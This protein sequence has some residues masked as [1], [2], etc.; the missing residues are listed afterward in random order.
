MVEEENESV[1]NSD[2]QPVHPATLRRS[3]F[4]PAPSEEFE[5]FS[6]NA[7][8]VDTDPAVPEPPLPES[9]MPEP[10]QRRSLDDAQLLNSLSIPRVGEGSVLGTIEE[11]QQ[12]LE[13]REQDARYFHQ[14]EDSMLAIGTPRAL[15]VVSE[16]RAVFTDAV[17]V[18]NTASQP[19]NANQAALKHE[20]VTDSAATLAPPKMFVEKDIIEDLGAPTLPAAPLASPR[21]EP[22]ELVIA[23]N[24]AAFEVGS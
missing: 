2:K 15:E 8:W 24:A 1:T 7:G 17:D 19:T 12:Q 22:E 16:T 6:A 13:L 18:V 23:A 14:W 3:N 10:P 21:T 11:L 4:T 20:P 9:P 5:R